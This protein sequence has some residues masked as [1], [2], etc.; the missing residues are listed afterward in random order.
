MSQKT[1]QNLISDNNKYNNNND[2]N[3]NDNNKYFRQCLLDKLKFR[4][5]NSVIVL[6]IWSASHCTEF[7]MMRI[8]VTKELN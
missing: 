8:F 2:D 5:I 3:D 4:L 7:C 6:A 1:K